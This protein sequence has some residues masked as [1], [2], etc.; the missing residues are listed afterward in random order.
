MN[1]RI[2]GIFGIW[3]IF[4]IFEIPLK[5]EFINLSLQNAKK[6]SPEKKDL[7]RIEKLQ[8]L[9]KIEK[10]KDKTLNIFRFSFLGTMFHQVEKKN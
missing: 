1:F 9:D 6:Y 3:G 4:E 2:F 10:G 5:L 7:D 8:I